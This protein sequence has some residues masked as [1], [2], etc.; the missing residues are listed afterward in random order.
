MVSRLKARLTFANVVALLAL[1][2][3]L[4][5][6]GYAAGA[7][8]FGSVGTNQLKFGSVTSNK[9]KD[10]TLKAADFAKNQLEDGPRGAS[11]PAGPAGP[12]GVV[13]TTQFYTKALS[14]AR[15]LRGG[16]VTVIGS[17]PAITVGTFGSATATCPSGFQAIAGGLSPS[18]VNSTLVTGSEPVVEGSNIDALADGQHAAPTAWRGF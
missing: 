14:D 5:G 13:D 3:A 18:N 16:V 15:F 6:T 9:V 1:F 11:G 10:G 4:G 12:A 2:V 7:L 17:N 8:P